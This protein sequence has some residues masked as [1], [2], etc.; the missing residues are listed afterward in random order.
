MIITTPYL[1]VAATAYS[2]GIEKLKLINIDF[3]N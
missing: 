2:K 1:A 3:Y